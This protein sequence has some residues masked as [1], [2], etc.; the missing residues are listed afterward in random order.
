[1]KRRSA[2]C[3]KLRRP[4]KR[5]RI[6]EGIYGRYRAAA[7]VKEGGG[8]LV[9]VRR[10]KRRTGTGTRCPGPLAPPVPLSGCPAPAP[11]SG[12]RARH[13]APSPP[14]GAAPPRGLVAPPLGRTGP[15]A[16][17]SLPSSPSPVPGSAETSGTGVGGRENAGCG[18]E[19][20]AKVLSALPGGRSGEEPVGASPPAPHT[21]TPPPWASH[22]CGGTG[23][24]GPWPPC[25]PLG[26]V[27]L[28]GG[29]SRLGFASSAKPVNCVLRRFNS[30]SV[31]ERAASGLLAFGGL[32]PFTLR[33]RNLVFTW[34]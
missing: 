31:A 17:L 5:N 29:F 22:L 4:L 12:G 1:M 15:S 11:V 10:R 3:S 27:S 13:G 2:D 23:R 14:S 21:H 25:F 16:C 20:L 28:A 9:A 24:G 34:W 18:G 7:G 33:L 26:V 8:G 19:L 32:Q 30:S 6:T